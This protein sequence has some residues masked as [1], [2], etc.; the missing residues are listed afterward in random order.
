VSTVAH[1][2]SSGCYVIA[3]LTVITSGIW[4]FVKLFM[5][6]ITWLVPPSCFSLTRR[7][8]ILNFLDDWGKY[9][10]LDSWFLV[11]TLSAFALEWQ[12]VGSASFKIQTTPANAFYTYLAATIL[13]L[14]LGHIASDC[15]RRCGAARAA[16]SSNASEWQV[17][18]GKVPLCNYAASQAERRVVWGMFGAAVV[19]GVLGTFCHSF[20]FE[21][22]GIF[23]QFLFG[24]SIERTYSVFSVGMSVANHRY[25]ETGL[26]GLEIVFIILALAVPTVLFGLLSVLW[27]KPM[28]VRQQKRLLQACHLLN[29]WACLDV[30]AL[31]LMIACFEFGK[32]AEW[33]IYEGNFGAPCTMVKDITK[34][35]CM[36]IE[37]HALPALTALFLAGVLLLAVPRVCMHKFQRA[38]QRRSG[39]DVKVAHPKSSN[40][41]QESNA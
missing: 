28:L 6:L 12:S 11:I 24:D 10:F 34:E 19:L 4:P 27:F 15:H 13:S 36:K 37:L 9:S 33:L 29:A 21:V 25:R 31:V 1:A 38:I 14:V 26:V 5:L 18:A 39:A 16:A 35:E 41:E 32:M 3:V 17:G 8:M 40:S 22:S 2:W 7:G 23:P 30:T 20:S